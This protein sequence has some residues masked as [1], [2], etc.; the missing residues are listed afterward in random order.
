MKQKLF[1]VL[2]FCAASAL[3]GLRAQRSPLHPMDIPQGQEGFY[4]TL[5]KWNPGTPPPGTNEFDDQFYVSRVRRLTRIDG[6]DD[7]QVNPSLDRNRK[8]CLWLPMD[9]PSSKWKSL[10]RYC[11]EG[12]N[13]GM[14]SYTDIHGNWTAPWMRLTAGVADVAHKNGVSV[15]CVF[16][17]PWAVSVYP[18][19][20]NTWGKHFYRIFQKEGTKYKYAEKLVKLMKYYGID[21]LGCNSEF[22]TSKDFMDNMI[23]FT[24]ACKE[25]AAR[26]NWRF[27]LHWY[28]LTADLGAI[29]MDQGLGAHND[30]IFGPASA[31]VTDMLFFNYNWYDDLLRRSVT[32][33][34]AMGR[35]SYDLY[36]GMDI[37]GRAFKTAWSVLKNHKISIG[38]WGAHSQSLLHQSATD[39]GSSD[40][41]IQKAYLMKQELS[42]SGGNRNPALTPA[43]RNDA[44]LAN[45]DLKTFHGMAAFLTAKSTLHTFPFVTRFNLGNGLFFNNEGKTTF[46]HKWHNIAVQDFLPTWRWWI[47]DRNDAVT[48]EGLAGLIKADFT[49]EDAWFGGSCLKIHGATDFSRVKLFKTKFPMKNHHELSITYKVLSGTDPKAKIFLATKGALTEYKEV[50][51]PAATEAGKWTTATFKLSEFGAVEGEHFNIAMV[52]I[53]FEGTDSGYGMLLGELSLC[54][55]TH[56]FVPVSPKITKVDI[57]RG[58]YNQVDFKLFYRSKEESGGVKTYND[59]VD[60]WY[61]EIWFQQKGQQAQLLTATTSWA[62]YVIDAPL[63][64]DAERKGRF[65]VRPVA[66]NG[67][68]TSPIVWSDEMEIPYNQALETIVTDKPVIKPDEEF[69]LKYEDLLHAPARKWEVKNPLTETVIASGEN[70][71]ELKL[72]I[73]EIGLYD[74]HTT[75]QDGQTSIQ[76]GL[77]QITPPET[78]SVPRILAFDSDKREAGTGETVTLICD[79]RN[80]DGKV[81]RALY[82]DGRQMFRAPAKAQDGYEYSYALWFKVEKYAH[83]KQGTNLINKNTIADKWPHNNWGDLWVT[84]RPEN[85]IAFNTMGWEAH[86]N[87][88]PNMKSTGFSVT[89]GIWNHV[90]VTQD[91]SK[92]Q[93]MY[94]NGKKV[95]ETVFAASSL[96]K[97]KN[98]LRIDKSVQADIFIGGGGVYKAGFTGWIDEMQVWNKA[99]SD[100]EVLQC[101]KGYQ[102]APEGLMAYYTFEEKTEHDVFVNQGK[103]ADMPGTVVIMDGSGG[104][105]TTEAAYVKQKADN[106]HVGYPGI[107]G[108]KEIKTLPV[109]HAGGS[110]TQ[111]KDGEKKLLVTYA[112]PGSYSI[113]LTVSNFWGKDE[114]VLQDHI[115]I[116]IKNNLSAQKNPELFVYPNPFVESVNMRFEEAGAYTLRLVDTKGQVV[117]EKQLNA[118]ENAMFTLQVNAPKGYYLLQVIKDNSLLSTM[119]LIKK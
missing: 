4:D 47:T 109:F 105:S 119:Q 13:F 29:V 107:V 3:Y 17:I 103:G 9:D 116:K 76:R 45:A 85:E 68:R 86:D 51:L 75:T 91:A 11:F 95:A 39:D 97:D 31:P 67:N 92:R 18:N 7:Y 114:K 63:T 70:L 100:E 28:D 8:L 52:G 102:E 12:D 117:Q 34:E 22:S 113:G 24:R 19:T 57:L 33:A 87:P 41:A 101:M 71:T 81:S 21:G 80:S 25:E 96:R 93:K 69:L 37:Q 90:V 32:K 110:A 30:G 89:P 20:Y 73:S 106:N 98:D 78:G 61:Y 79:Y 59:E 82:L 38:L 64:L 27:E 77:I 50:A 6:E 26:I 94:F 5:E 118:D 10:P 54:D 48:K 74:L 115:V 14:W 49:F 15:G 40:L 72:K 99:L 84:I 42:F 112:N 2:C 108:S 46:D 111:V 23:A 43:I 58:R 60:T 55:P 88:N 35:S 62:A 83:D 44:T 1:L 65:G 16:S 36:A 66:P 53:A 56:T 104:E